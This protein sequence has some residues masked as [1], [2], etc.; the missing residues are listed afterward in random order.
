MY[1][2]IMLPSW[3]S[4]LTRAMAAARLG[5]G[6]GMQLEIQARLQ[7]NAFLDIISMC[8]LVV[9]EDSGLDLQCRRN[10]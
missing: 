8:I 3:E 9:L 10:R 7:S 4:M 2:A 1:E 6:R 5:A